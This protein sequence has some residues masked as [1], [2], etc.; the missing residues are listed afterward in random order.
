[1]KKIRFIFLFSLI[2]ILSSCNNLFNN[3]SEDSDNSNYATLTGTLKKEGAIHQRSAFPSVPTDKN[4][5]VNVTATG[6]TWNGAATFS[7]DKSSFTITGLDFDTIW[8]IEVGIED[9]ASSAIYMKDSYTMDTSEKLSAENQIF[10]HDFVLKPLQTEDKGDFSLEFEIEEGCGIASIGYDNQ[11]KTSD[12]SGN[13]ATITVY[14]VSPGSYEREFTFW[15]GPVDSTNNKCTGTLLYSLTE[16]INISSNLTTDTWVRNADTSGSPYLVNYVDEHGNTKTKCYI[17]KALIDDYKQRTFYVKQTGSDTAS[18]TYFKPLQTIEAAIMK[19]D[20]KDIDYNIFVIGELTVSQA[21]PDSLTNTDSGTYKARSVTICGYNGLNSSGQPQDSINGNWGDDYEEEHNALDIWQTSVPISV[22]NLLITGGNNSLPGG[23]ISNKGDLTLLSGCVVNGNKAIQGGGVYNTGKL[24]ITS[25]SV[26]S[27]NEAKGTTSLD[28][29]GGIYNYNGTV[30]MSGGQ[31][32]SNTAIRGGGIYNIIDDESKLAVV[33]IYGD[34]VIGGDTAADGNTATVGSSGDGGGG[35][36]NKGG[37]VYFGCTGWL[38]TGSNTEADYYDPDPAKKVEWTGKMSHNTAT[39]GWGGGFINHVT[40]IT[41]W[42]PAN[43]CKGSSIVHMVSGKI[44]SNSAQSGG[45]IAD[46]NGA[47]LRIHGGT[48]G[49]ASASEGNTA[50]YEG[51]GILSQGKPF[52]YGGTI[53]YNTAANRGGGVSMVHLNMNGGTI[54]N[55]TATNLGGAAYVGRGVLLKNDAYIPYGTNKKN[56]VYLELADD[57]SYPDYGKIVISSALTPP[58]EC[59]DGIVA[60]ITP[61]TYEVGK[62]I[63]YQSSTATTTIADECTKFNI[64]DNDTTDQTLWVIN[65]DGTLQNGFI[66]TSSNIDN[67]IPNNSTVYNIKA[68]SSLTTNNINTLMTKLRN[69]DGHS[70][71]G[72]KEGTSLDLSATSVTNMDTNMWIYSGITYLIL[73]DNINFIGSQV[74]E[75][76]KELKEITISS[77]NTNFITEDGILYNKSKTKLIRY[78]PKKEGNQFTL[79]DTVIELE[80]GAFEYNENLISI[81]GLNHIHTAGYLVFAYSKK[82]EEVDFSGLTQEL[83]HYK[84]FYDCKIKKVILSPTITKIGDLFTYCSELREIHFRSTEPPIIGANENISYPPDNVIFQNCNA[85]LKFYVP[86]GSKAAYL[87]DTERTGC[88]NG[89]LN[90]LVS[91][92]EDV[93]I[94]E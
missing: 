71:L 31:I 5:Y 46:H 49:G 78:P 19:M 26:I 40:S 66:V 69:N 94:E 37:L 87:A 6:K 30:I 29:G 53:S 76:N 9:E 24:T 2:L 34:A 47:L 77:S 83:L 84:T 41:S 54:K 80:Y 21:I 60:T 17:T 86:S 39:G 50:T 75:N 42:D 51:G 92:L 1:M 81:S 12:F 48:I 36:L 25:G 91:N 10:T 88:F 35:F 33:Y 63:L 58:A 7:E 13:K 20:N 57:P 32:K 61:S 18:G 28:G 73:P 79:P 11:F 85:N 68:D 56:D 4:Y 23:G 3:K 90:Y 89:P 65:F 72:V 16:I 93:I 15:S 52:I 8:T 82:I 55:N 22:K 67:F 27:N 38:G 45:G 74:F 62:T 14:S 59:T 70:N 43:K 64:V 44:C